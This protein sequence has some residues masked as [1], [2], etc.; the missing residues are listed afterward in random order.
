MVDT[1]REPQFMAYLNGHQ[2]RVWAGLLLSGG[3]NDMI[4]AAHQSPTNSPDLRLLATQDEWTAAPGGERYLSNAGWQTFVD[5]ITAVFKE[6][7]AAR[8]RGPN[9]G[10]PIVW[11]SYD[12]STPRNSPAG[13]G[14]GPWLYP[15]VLAYGIPQADWGSVAEALLGRLETLLDHIAANTADGSVHVVHAQ[16]TLTP[17]LPTDTGATADWQNEIHPTSSGYRMLSARWQPVL[18]AVFEGTIQVAAQGTATSPGDDGGGG[19]R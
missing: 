17:A 2:S 18:T 13:L 6:L 10:I 8:D 16:G 15:A 5:H 19:D 7:L 14:F 9:I 1:T 12:I 4:S 11:H 3:G